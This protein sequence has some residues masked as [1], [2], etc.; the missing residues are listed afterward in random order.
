MNKLKRYFVEW[1]DGSS[2][3]NDIGY[4]YNEKE[5]IQDFYDNCRYCKNEDNAKL[6]VKEQVLTNVI[7]DLGR[8]EL[9]RIIKKADIL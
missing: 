2:Q 9:I 7:L 8:D 5:G 1:K 3:G 4:G 6:K